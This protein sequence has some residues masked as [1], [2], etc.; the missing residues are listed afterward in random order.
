[1]MREKNNKAEF[2]GGWTTH[3]HITQ[4][5]SCI[6]SLVFCMLNSSYLGIPKKHGRQSPI[7]KWKVGLW[8]VMIPR[9][10][11]GSEKQELTQ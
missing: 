5:A 2:L 9:I 6:Y 10:R 8:R 4:L 11:S 1:M 3:T 7:Q